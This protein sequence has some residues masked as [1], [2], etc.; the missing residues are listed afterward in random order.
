MR[1]CYYNFLAGTAAISRTRVKGDLS[2]GVEFYI[3]LLISKLPPELF[4]T[5]FA[6]NL[7]KDLFI[8]YFDEF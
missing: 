2:T 5:V 1:S 4:C 8:W 6:F 3:V 7:L